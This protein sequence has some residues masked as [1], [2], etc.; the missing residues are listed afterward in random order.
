[1]S[2][3]STSQYSVQSYCAPGSRYLPARLAALPV[4]YPAR[5]SLHRRFPCQQLCTHRVCVIKCACN[6][7]VHII[8]IYYKIS[9]LVLVLIASNLH[10]NH[11]PLVHLMRPHWWRHVL[12]TYK[13]QNLGV[14]KDFS[15][16]FWP[17]NRQSLY[18]CGNAPLNK[19]RAKPCATS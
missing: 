18:L 11:F 15:L 14:K 9:I 17:F 10:L 6:K 1:M 4:F 16:R 2:E 13:T 19:I 7:Y 12:E 8:I 3:T 5:L